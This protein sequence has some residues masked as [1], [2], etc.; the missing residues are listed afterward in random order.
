MGYP[1]V[2]LGGLFL[3]LSPSPFFF[4]P[5]LKITQ[6]AT[7]ADREQGD[8]AAGLVWE[9]LHDGRPMMS[10]EGWEQESEEA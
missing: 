4:F 2:P 3:S 8:I 10:R 6:L 7:Y 1:R 5:F 9:R